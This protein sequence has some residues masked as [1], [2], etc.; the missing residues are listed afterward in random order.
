MKKTG[1]DSD[2][3]AIWPFGRKS[4]KNTS[5][6]ADPAITAVSKRSNTAPEMGRK[7]ASREASDHSVPTLRHRP[8][9]RESQKRPRS[10]SRKLSKVNAPSIRNAEKVDTIPPIPALPEERRKQLSEKAGANKSNQ[11]PSAVPPEDRDDIPSYY[12]QNPASASSLQPEKFSVIYNPPTLQG[13]RAANDYGLPRRKS[14]KRKVDDRAREK[15]IKSMTSPIPIPKRPTSYQTSPLARDS[16]QVPGGMNRNLERPLSEISLPM[17]ESM[18]SQ[19]SYSSENYGFKINAFDA[20]SPRPTIRYSSN[21]RSP[22]G[23]AGPSRTS[24]RKDKQPT[25]PEEV[26]HSRKRIDDL[27]DD[28]DAGSLRELMERDKRRHEKRRK[29]ENERLQRRLERRAARDKEKERAAQEGEADLVGNEKE[30]EKETEERK[31]KERGGWMGTASASTSRPT[32][33]ARHSS[34][35]ERP[36]TPESWLRDPSREYLVPENPFHDPIAGASRSHLEEAT[37]TPTE[38]QDDPVLETAKAVQVSSA[39]LSPTPSRHAHEPSNLSQ[40]SELATTPTPEAPEKLDPDLRRDSDTSNR[41][42][43]NW[44]SIFRR[45]DT[46]AKRDS[47]DR[48]RATPSEFSNT[49]RES[50]TRQMPPSAFTRISQVRSTTPKRTQ[51]RFKEDLPELPV[52]SPDSRMQ[53]PEDGGQSSLPPVPGSRGNDTVIDSPAGVVANPAIPDEEKRLSDIHPAFREEVAMSR[54]ASLRATS[55]EGP[56]PTAHLS[57]SLASVDSEGSWLTGRPV[58][59]LSQPPPPRESAGSLGQ[60]VGEFEGSDEEVPGTP[61]GQKYIGTLA[62]ADDEKPA[63]PRRRRPFMSPRGS[64][65]GNEDEDESLHPAPIVTTEEEGTWHGAIGK[66]PTIVRQGPGPRIKSREGL[67][68]DFQADEESQSSSPSADSPTSPDGLSIQRATSVDFGKGHARH[69]SA[70]SARLLNLPPRSSQEIRRLS[71]GSGSGERSPLGPRE[72]M[73]SSP[74]APET[75]SDD[76]D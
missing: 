47:A 58:K 21:P 43:S 73:S 8:S 39:S 72:E 57:Q 22:A 52:T 12:F 34:A 15:E 42:S 70:G 54:Q 46:R 18:Q 37:P 59:R 48:G 69:I 74:K 36:K 68:N 13:K 49:S 2:D 56:N 44:K 27:A 7:E 61:E 10:S 30:E 14:S 40:L 75:A 1:D 24:T 51:S 71:S 63:I 50:I 76:V 53:S 66:N 65:M 4:K 16:R 31:E 35:D 38:E 29:S 32:V 17:A 11:L 20:L 67:L 55:P 60:A 23:S 5:V 19:F 33:K 9:R 41:F 62:P 3:M 6:E 26:V 28:M 64:G 25:I 45:S